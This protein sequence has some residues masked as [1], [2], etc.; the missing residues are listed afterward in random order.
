LSERRCLSFGSVEVMS[1]RT[2][3]AIAAASIALLAG[4][5]AFGFDASTVDGAVKA[6]NAFGFDFYLQSRRG[7]YNFVCSPAGA[8]I[9]LT[10]VAAGAHGETQAEILHTLHIDSE[11]LPENLD[12]TYGSFA[13]ILTALKERDGKDG[14][15]LNMASRLWIRKDLEPRPAYVSLLHDVFRTPL[16]EVDFDNWGKAAVA[17]INQWASDETHGRVP[18]ILARL[19]GTGAFVL[20]NVV[21]MTGAWQQ[22]FEERATYDAKF[23]NPPKN[24]TT[25]KMMKQLRRFGY[26]QVDGAKLVE[27]P[28]WGGL[29]MIV[30]LPDEF[31]GLEKIENRLG[32]HYAEWVGALEPQGVDLE[33][34]RFTTTTALP[35]VDLLKAMGILRAFD[36]RQAN[37]SDMANASFGEADRKNLYIGDAIQKV[38]IETAASVITIHHERRKGLLSEPPPPV[39]FHANHPFMYVVR[40]VKS[41]EILFMGRMVKPTK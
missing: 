40:D 41:G 18:Q 2:T 9:A 26:A 15:A 6:N 13:A 24:R 31:D 29:S 39:I 25:V 10:M 5:R 14:L 34:P 21:S 11:N 1:T 4:G 12:K 38:R 28:Y 17:A 7:Q 16:P 23:N 22:P 19:S 30:V 35:L 20:A 37:F 33:L 27:L 8:A 36:R 3:T 32:G